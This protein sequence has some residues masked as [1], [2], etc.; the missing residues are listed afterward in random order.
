MV[1]DKIMPGKTGLA[2]EMTRGQILRITDLEGKQVVDMG[3]FDRA[4][5][6]S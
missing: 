2:V 4:N 6:R 3:V 5:P 1:F